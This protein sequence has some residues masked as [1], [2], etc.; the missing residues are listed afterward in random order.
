MPKQ[1]SDSGRGKQAGRV[2]YDNL[3]VIADSEKV[4]PGFEDRLAG[5][6]VRKIRI[7]IC[8]FVNVKELRAGNSRFFVLGFSISPCRR[9]MP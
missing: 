6:H 8:D 3:A 7:G 5:N 2:V 1:P 9:Q 4:H